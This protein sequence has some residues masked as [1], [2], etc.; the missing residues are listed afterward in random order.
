MRRRR[1]N[2]ALLA[3]LSTGCLATEPAFP[4][5]LK[6]EWGSD[7]GSLDADSS[8]VNAAFMCTT[9]SVPGPVSFDADR[10]F[11][12]RGIETS[13]FGPIRFPPDTQPVEM[14]G[15]LRAREDPLTLDLTLWMIDSTG[16]RTGTPITMTVQ[17]G[18]MGKTYACPA[19]FGVGR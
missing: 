16:G 10:S 9:V 19:E 11:D 7:Q 3:L 17:Q 14:L 6:G 18:V 15:T 13:E 12:V 4:G 2:I 1:L 5:I 8:Q